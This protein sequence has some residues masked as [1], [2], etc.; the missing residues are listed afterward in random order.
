MQNKLLGIEISDLGV[1]AAR[2]GE[3][4]AE[5]IPLDG[6]TTE[7]SAFAQLT[8]QGEV[9]FG[10]SAFRQFH[11]SEVPVDNQY[12]YRLG[13]VEDA[14]RSKKGSKHQPPDEDLAQTHLKAVFEK[15]LQGGVSFEQIAIA[16]PGHFKASKLGSVI[17]AAQQ[18]GISVNHVLDNSLAG[19]LSAPVVPEG[20]TLWV[21]DVHWSA[22]DVVR[23]SR[24]ANAVERSEVISDR[25]LGL[26]L[27]LD[28]LIDGVGKRFIDECR[29]DPM[30]R[31]E[32][33]QELYNQVFD[34]LSDSAGSGSQIL[35]TA[36]GSITVDRT[37]LSGM[38]E[39]ELRGLQQMVVKAGGEEGSILLSSRAN[40]IPGF[41]SGLKSEKASN[42]LSM[43]S[44]QSALGALAFM[45]SL[46]GGQSSDQPLY[47][48]RV[49]FS[50]KAQVDP[51]AA[52]E[53][54]GTGEKYVSGVSGVLKP[55]K[56]THL[57]FQGRLLRLPDNGDAKF[58]VGKDKGIR[59]GLTIVEK[60]EGLADGHIVL[61]RRRDGEIEMVNNG[62]NTTFL[63]GEAVPSSK[64]M[65]LQTGDVI[66]LGDS[67][68]QLM[69]TGLADSDA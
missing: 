11:V 12:W 64:T 43:S 56:P 58:I 27:I 9:V 25:G 2:I 19:L 1:S 6:N 67:V 39:T 54:T 53:G 7:L 61:M 3:N 4:G 68:L 49:E 37:I 33:A 29:F 47:H 24:L 40:M 45:H 48:T 42:I 20:E 63:N 41:L 50:S 26:R 36:K 69:I 30:A 22:A 34:C 10:R 14:S 5:L 51:D 16:V 32:Y 13:G 18:A 28:R 38:I 60:V 65:V 62:R 57:L 21:V 66:T 46:G 23:I 15:C 17:Q 35:E 8:G 31:P 55:T 44:G 59:S 52:L